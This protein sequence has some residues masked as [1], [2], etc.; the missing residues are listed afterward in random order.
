MQILS[1]GTPAGASEGE[2]PT[3]SCDVTTIERADKDDWRCVT[4]P[5]ERRR[6]QNRLNQRAY[7]KCPRWLSHS[8]ASSGWFVQRDPE[9]LAGS[10]SETVSWSTRGR[11][12][13]SSPRKLHDLCSPVL[14]PGPSSHRPPISPRQSQRI[15]CLPTK[16]YRV[17]S[18][19][20]RHL[21]SRSR[22]TLQPDWSVAVQ[23]DHIPSLLAADIMS[24]LRST[25]SVDWLLSASNSTG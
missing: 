7:S 9:A 5:A 25:S 2:M 12:G 21:Q 19:R 23:C 17:R 22:I 3:I 13:G 1:H 15:P 20:R 6:R 14:R 11:H 8:I 24:A 10:S 4:N 18:S 16:Y